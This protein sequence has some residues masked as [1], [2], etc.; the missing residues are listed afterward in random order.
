M[1]PDHL[2]RTL[3]ILL[4]NALRNG[5]ASAALRTWEPGAAGDL[6]V[7]P[8]R[9]FLHDTNGVPVLVDLAAMRDAM[10]AQGKDPAL[11]DPL[12]PAELVVDHSVIADAFGRPDA[13]RLNVAL[14]YERNAERFRFLR[15]GQRTF[16]Q[17]KVVPPGA[18]IMHQINLE[19]LA[20]VVE[21]RD[22]WVFPD[23][24]L[25]TDSHTTMVNGL[26]VL[27]WGIGGIEAEAAMLGQ[28]VSMVLPRVVGVRLTGALPV[29]TTATDLVLTITETLRAHGVVGKLVEFGGPALADMPVPDRATIANMSPEFGSTAAYFP[30]DQRTLDYLLFTGRSPQ[31]VALVESYAREQGLWHDPS[32]NLRYDEYADIDLGAVVP[33]IAGPRRPQQRASLADARSAVEPELPQ[34]PRTGAVPGHGAVVV[35]AI[36]SC[37][38]TSNPAVMVAA[39]LLA[40][41]AVERGLTSK[42]WVK[43]TLSPG[44][45]VVVDYLGDAGLT[46]YLEKLGFHLAGFGCM[47]C[48][49]ASGALI[50]SVG[51]AVRAQDLTV[52]AV[53]SGNRNFEG[54]IQPDVRLNYLASP[55]LVV[56]YALAG[57]MDIDLLTEPLGTTDSGEPVHLADLWPD[58]ADIDAVMT[59]TLRP[60]LFSSAYSDVFAG[61][62][63]WQ[64]LDVPEGE[65]FAW[66]D[67]T[68]LQRPPYFDQQAAPGD[69]IGARALVR[70]GDSVTTDHISPAGAIPADSVAGRYLRDRGVTQLNTYASRRGNHHVMVR[71][72]FGNVRLRNRLAQGVE[73]PVTPGPDGVLAPIFDAAEAYRAAGVPVVVVAGKEYGTGSSRDWAAKGPALLGVRAVLAQSFE[74]IHRSNL[75][76][77]G[78]LPLEFLPGEGDDLTGEEPIDIRLG[79]D[80]FATAY[81]AGKKYRL[82]VRLD[83]P[84]ETEYYRHGGVL[85]FVLHRLTAEPLNRQEGNG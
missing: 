43:T 16:R 64:R 20:R 3:R 13:M 76:G 9:V 83:T 62:E 40:R 70:L 46:P 37:T 49:G 25:G 35:A 8:S 54:R 84:R 45:R 17:V 59:E 72:A 5:T 22:G 65:I 15:W 48:I 29:G 2:P 75:V 51:A 10:A 32:A 82:Q 39:G 47:T 73:G 80:G 68:Y 81:S 27:G 55:P 79:D 58:P 61:D 7:H 11:V 41:N 42:P 57:R 14:E 74:R 34:G 69:L 52:A 4:E 28:S 44:S 19:H 67:S 21:E 63:R 71:G 12:V 23:L 85:P 38:N 53:L 6:E 60:E 33:S 77:L 66:G 31:K 78:I 30:I 26:G 18:G 1:A 56:A 24:C 36:T 50:D